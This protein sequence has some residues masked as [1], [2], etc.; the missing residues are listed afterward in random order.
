M[1]MII[2]NVKHVE[3]NTNIESVVLSKQTLKML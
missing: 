3:L 2:K 1:N